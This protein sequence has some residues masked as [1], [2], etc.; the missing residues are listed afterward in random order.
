MTMV[1]LK[2]CLEKAEYS[3]LLQIAMVELRNPTDQAHF[4]LRQ[5]LERRG[6]LPGSEPVKIPA[7]PAGDQP[8][9]SGAQNENAL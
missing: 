2:L 9:E 6:L 5:D 8:K 3:A 1:R 7:L 4:I